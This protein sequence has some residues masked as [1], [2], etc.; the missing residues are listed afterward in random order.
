M[1]RWDL[2]V[3]KRSFWGWGFAHFL[4]FLFSSCHVLYNMFITLF[5]N[6]TVNA[7]PFTLQFWGKAP[8]ISK[9]NRFLLL[10]FFAFA[11]R[12]YFF[13]FI[14]ADV[15]VR[16]PPGPECTYKGSKK[17]PFGLDFPPT[18]AAKKTDTLTPTTHN[19]IKDFATQ[20]H[21]HNPKTQHT[22]QNTPPTTHTIKKL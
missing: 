16:L 14:F 1:C 13:L 11:F 21:T 6:T 18:H 8:H 2:L 19:P 9:M 15:R 17:H 12:S 20:T 4:F 22:T 5:H 10:G 7:E 3:F